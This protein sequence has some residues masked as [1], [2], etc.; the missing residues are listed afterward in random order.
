MVS[1]STSGSEYS[2]ALAHA[3]CSLSQSGGVQKC[4]VGRSDCALV[5]QQVGQSHY[6]VG[7]SDCALMDQQVG[8][9]HYIVGSSDCALM[10]Q[11]VGQSHYMHR[12]RM[13]CTTPKYVE[14]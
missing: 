4:I 2:W 6:I 8:Q 1:P 5:D 9:S 10:D 7:R 11:Q 14:S 3:V 13:A 12:T